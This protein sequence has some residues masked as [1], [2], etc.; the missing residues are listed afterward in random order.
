[1]DQILKIFPEEKY[2][3]NNEV[4]SRCPTKSSNEFE[5]YLRLSIDKD[6]S[7]KIKKMIENT[8]NQLFDAIQNKV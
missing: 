7:E 8:G 1:L 5:N 4:H 3:I 6:R 2:L